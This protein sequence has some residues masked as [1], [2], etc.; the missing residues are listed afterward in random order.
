MSR[1]G[2]KM[3]HRVDI[4]LPG[5]GTV[6]IKVELPPGS[7][8][9]FFGFGVNHELH[10]EL[11]KFCRNDPV[12]MDVLCRQ[13]TEWKGRSKSVLD[14]P[15]LSA[16]R[17]VIALAKLRKLKSTRENPNKENGESNEKS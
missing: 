7:E 1:K 13:L 15:Q 16:K 5:G 12:E 9:E 8:A 10:E 3:M 4:K 6:T 17:A 2:K 14:I 11:K